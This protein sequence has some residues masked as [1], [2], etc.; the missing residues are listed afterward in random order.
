MGKPDFFKLK[1]PY[2]I[3]SCVIIFWKQVPSFFTDAERRSVMAAAQ[4]AGLNCL[5]L[6]NET[7][8]GKG[9]QHFFFKYPFRLLNLRVMTYSCY[10]IRSLGK[11][12]SRLVLPNPSW[13]LET[14]QLFW[15]GG[16]QH[17]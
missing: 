14:Q 3:I 13:E 6:M 9:Q 17:L 5:K 16:V 15:W 10:T 1:S 11:K 4:I 7:T 12:L 2:F 8:A